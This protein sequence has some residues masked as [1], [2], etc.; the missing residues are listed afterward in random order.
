MNKAIPELNTCKQDEI[1][2][3]NEIWVKTKMTFFDKN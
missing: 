2:T 1:N 3:I